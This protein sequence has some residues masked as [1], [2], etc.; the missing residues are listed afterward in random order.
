MDFQTVL[1]AD[2]QNIST[3]QRDSSVTQGASAVF[4]TYLIGVIR[5]VHRIREELVTVDKG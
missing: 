3:S 1:A 2:R 5:A 4:S